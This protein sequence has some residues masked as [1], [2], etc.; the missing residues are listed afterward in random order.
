MTPIF[1]LLPGAPIGSSGRLV[2]TG[3]QW[4]SWIHLDDIAGIFLMAV[5]ASNATGPLNGTAPNAVRNAQF[6]KTLSAV[7]RKPY[8]PWRIFVPAGPPDFAIQLML[9][10]VASV[11]T[12]GQKVLPTKTLA[13]GYHFRFPNLEEALRD[14][15]AN[16]PQA[17]PRSDAPVGAG[18]HH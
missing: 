14:I 8:T 5:E 16:K 12:A 13:A 17:A 3:R 18:A 10:E 7:L 9:G 11:I 2:A 1:K 6:A 4:M 15:F